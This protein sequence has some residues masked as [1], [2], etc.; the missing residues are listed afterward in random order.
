[1]CCAAPLARDGVFPQKRKAMEQAPQFTLLADGDGADRLVLTG[2]LLVST[3]AALDADLRAL[4]ALGGNAPKAIDIAAV[5]EID[6]AGAWLVCRLAQGWGAK[7]TGAS[8]KAARL[9]AAVISTSSTL[10]QP[11]GLPSFQFNPPIVQ[12]PRLISETATSVFPNLRY[13][14]F[15][16][17]RIRIKPPFPDDV[18][19]RTATANPRPARRPR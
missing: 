5:T 6:T 2:G 7:V 12:Q 13:F 9:I 17:S 4:S 15:T 14:I 18:W 3:M 11:T 16:P 19:K 1:V 10:A 8:D